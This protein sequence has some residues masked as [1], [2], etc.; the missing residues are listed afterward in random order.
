MH[1]RDLL[2]HIFLFTDNKSIANLMLLNL[3]PT[4]QINY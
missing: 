1:N 2:R 4:R 3:T